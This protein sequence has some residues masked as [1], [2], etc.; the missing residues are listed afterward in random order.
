MEKDQDKG[1]FM[2]PE[3]AENG[4]TFFQSMY[5]K[6]RDAILKHLDDYQLQAHIKNIISKY[7]KTLFDYNCLGGKS[8]RGTLVIL[9]YEYV[10]NRDINDVEWE[11]AACLAWCIEILQ[12]SFL[13]ADDIM[14]NGETRRNKFCWYLLKDVETKNAINDVLFLYN[15]VYKLIEIF[16]RTDNCYTNILSAFRDISLKTLI[17]QHLDTNIFSAKYLKTNIKN[18]NVIDVNDI[19]PPE[20]IKIN[21]A[22]INMKVYKDIVIH[23][24]AYYSF[25]LPIVCGMLL[26]D[27]EINNLL[28]KKI[29]DVSLL[30]G[31][32]FQVRDD[33]L[34]IYGDSNKMG[35]SG[36]D[37]QNNKL[38][39]L[40]V[41]VFEIASEEDKKKIVKNYGKNNSACVKIVKSIYDLYK[42]PK[43]FKDYEQEM[44]RNITTAINGLHHEG[45]E[46]VLKHIINIL[47]VSC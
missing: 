32:Y 15:S 19:N 18:E 23:K 17:G 46:Y 3:E 24:T 4:L 22:V 43:H 29:E 13:V 6:Y 30:M 33:Y 21:T 45:I 14:D 16:L 41:K 28:Y 26:A 27:I 11:K 40:L 20:N 8:N 5:D 42:L 25:F 31:E 37:I 7:Y 35:K 38:T 9:I 1:K 44:K 12:A 47:F 34:D 36:T 39:W 2:K 10:K